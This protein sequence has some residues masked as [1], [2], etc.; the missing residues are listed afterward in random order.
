VDRVYLDYA[1]TSPMDPKTVDRMIPF[2]TQQFGNPSSL[3]Y[4]G[5]QADHAVDL[6]RN[7]ILRLFKSLDHDL[8]FT[9][10][11]T[12]SDNLALKGI[13][14]SSN[15]SQKKKILISPVEHPA[16]DKT[17]KRLEQDGTAQ[18]DQLRVD[19]YG[20]ILHNDLQEKLAGTSLVSVVWANNEIGTVNDIGEIAQICHK[21]GVLLH[22]DAVQAAAHININLNELDIDLLSIGAHKFCGPKGVGCLVFRKSINLDAQNVG[23][24]QESGIRGGTHNVPLI[25]GMQ[26]ALEMAYQDR[27]SINL[28]LT[29]LRDQIIAETLKKI[30]DSY[31][32]GHPA[33][34]LPNHASF[35]FE[36]VKGQD[37]V[38]AL[39]MAGFSVSSGSACKVG[40]PSPSQVLLAIGIPE[41]LAMGALRVTVGRNT[42]EDEVRSFLEILPK[43]VN[44]LRNG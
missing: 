31:L 28:H 23:G 27:E 3:H 20:L 34:R 35:V 8:V 29:T 2:F 40:N 14:N 42:K 41:D 33:Y 16:V 43:I 21:S 6:A 13:T 12:E 11:G 15:L 38:I 36:G 9:S 1:A 30:P 5:Q 18:L 26:A 4:F 37:L 44:N 17:A 25:V 7:A 19:K 39:D 10:G 24:G 32:T 22:T